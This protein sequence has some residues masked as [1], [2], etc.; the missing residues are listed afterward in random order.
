MTEDMMD[1]TALLAKSGD[2]D[3]LRETIGYA[4]KRLMELEVGGHTGAPFGEKSAGRLAQRNSLPR[5]RPGAIATAIG[6]PAPGRLSCA[7]RAFAP[8]TISPAFWSR[9]AWWKR[10][11]S[12]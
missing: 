5:R 8:A 9:A 4:A 6:K 12:G 1:L 2:T 7:S 10:R 3:F 11:G